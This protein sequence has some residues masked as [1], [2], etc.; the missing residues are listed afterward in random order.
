MTFNQHGPI[1]FN[2][3]VKK[4]MIWK[5]RDLVIGIANGRDLF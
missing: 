1:F 4:R 2:I 5:D 3:A